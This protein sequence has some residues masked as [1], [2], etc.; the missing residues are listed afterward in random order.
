MAEAGEFVSDG[1]VL[2]QHGIQVLQAL[3]L[4]AH[5]GEVSL[6]DVVLNGHFKVEKFLRHENHADVY[7]ICSIDSQTTCL[8]ARA[9]PLEGISR[10]VRQYRLRNIK[11]LSSRTVLET[12]WQGMVIV[13]YKAGGSK[14]EDLENSM[15]T[16]L[17]PPDGKSDLV[18]VNT[19]IQ[20]KTDHQREMA[21]IRQFERR[22]S[23][24]R[25]ERR[26]KAA[27]T[28]EDNSM[29]GDKAAI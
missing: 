4:D 5:D 15:H 21:R 25:R 18:M 12:Q 8:E 26:L 23:N 11:R 22:K 27:E 24:R 2:K 19:K 3:D 29:K 1:R 7:S 6:V 9:Y 10:K 14:P 16:E 20:Q 13:V 17:L 28:P